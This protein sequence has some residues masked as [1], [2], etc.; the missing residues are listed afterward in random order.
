MVLV[1]GD[2]INGLTS[3]GILVIVYSR[4]NHS[5]VSYNFVPHPQDRMAIDFTVM[6][7]PYVHYEV[8]VFVV[9]E[10]GLPFC[11]AAAMPRTVHN[12][13]KVVGIG[14]HA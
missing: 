2:V 11:R 9:E 14:F 10:S 3:M 5:D 7:L 6:G 13:S 8:S 1:T 4:L 12:N